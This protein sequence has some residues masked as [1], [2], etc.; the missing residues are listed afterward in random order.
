MG[1]SDFTIIAVMLGI[2]F[3]SV[4]I[5]LALMVFYPEWVGITGKETKEV[6]KKRQMGLEVKEEDD[7]ISKWQ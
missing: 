6:E 3:F 4:M 7:I 5:Y 1:D 2:F